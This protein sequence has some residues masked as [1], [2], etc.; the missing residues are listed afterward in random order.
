MLLMNLIFLL[1]HCYFII[2]SADFWGSVW[3]KYLCTT[4]I[5]V[6]IWSSDFYSGLV[7]AI[8]PAYPLGLIEGVTLHRIN[9]EFAVTSTSAIVAGQSVIVLI[10]WK[11]L[12]NIMNEKA[13]NLGSTVTK[14][15]IL[16]EY[17]LNLIYV[18][19]VQM[20]RFN[21]QHYIN[22]GVI[23]FCE[24]NQKVWDDWMDGPVVNRACWQQS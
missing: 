20:I 19:N 4:Q 15:S 18:G 16:L 2:F 12:L 10:R 1:R 17:W 9:V 6:C 22:H 24:D 11:N 21:T 5:K 23:Q 3:Q 7:A 14:S 13:F 8:T